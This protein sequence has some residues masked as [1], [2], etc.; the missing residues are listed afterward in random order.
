MDDDS[1][2]TEFTYN[3]PGE[4][5]S[6][7][8]TIDTVSYTTGA[9]YN[10]M[11]QLKSV[12]YPGAGGE[13]VSYAYD[14]GGFLTQVSSPL[15]TYAVFSNNYTVLGQP[16]TLTYGDGAQTTHEYSPLT[17][18]L[19][20]L[21]TTKG[22]LIQDLRYDYDNIGNI[23][24]ITDDLQR[25]GVN[26]S[27]GFTYDHLNRLK[28]A[29]FISQLEGQIVY[30]YGYD[31]IG[32]ITSV[33][34]SGGPNP[35]PNLARRYPRTIHYNVDNLPYEILT[36]QVVLASFVYD[37]AGKRVSKTTG[38]TTTLYIG[39]IYES[40]GGVSTN[41]IFAGSRR[42]ASKTTGGAVFYYHADHLG[43]LNAATSNGT[44]G[45]Q[46]TVAYNPFGEVRLDT[47]NVN[48]DYKFTGKEYDP[49]AGGGA[50][51][52]D[53]LYYY[54]ARYYD[55]VVGRF[56]SP[57]S[58]VPNPG[59]PQS[60]NR[61]AYCLNNPINVID[62]TGHFS[63]GSFFSS[64]AGGII[65]AF[66]FAFTGDPVLS[67]VAA[68]GFSGLM[69]G[70]LQNMF[71]GALMG[72]VS[73]GLGMVV[74]A[75]FG[76]AGTLAMLGIGA[77]SAVATGG[78]ESL[79]YMG[80][81]VVGG[82]IGDYAAGYAARYS[83]NESAEFSKAMRASSGGYDADALVTKIDEYPVNP[84]GPYTSK[85]EAAMAA[86]QAVRAKSASDL[87]YEWGCWIKVAE[88]DLKAFYG[89]YDC[90][91]YTLI[92][93]DYLVD[94]VSPGLKPYGAVADF[95]SHVRL[96]PYKFNIFSPDDKDWNRYFGV[97]GYLLT[98]D[99]GLLRYNP[100]T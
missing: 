47:G 43:S 40:T 26:Y 8:K 27:Q 92:R 63:L 53:G 70:N 93:S 24:T 86:A 20:T 22:S 11:G 38:A 88:P 54:G 74:Q 84:N 71:T 58:I 95:H 98:P 90:Y 80:A 66:T 51:A 13:T 100:P 52:T 35:Y 5:I 18:R 28:T 64:L 34:N 19:H 14:A 87:R 57:D 36:N 39:D 44:N 42:I 23:L 29:G 10:A 97:S 32:N 83:A 2:R 91:D 7:T 69:S 94:R 45:P 46:E 82:A 61:Y 17:N 75:N 76:T 9:T 62:P 50:G 4:V 48:L 79:A 15:T 56:I 60:L 67:G 16:G 73:G 25:P 77:G 68:G 1:G 6:T 12:T 65:G 31:K 96:Y 33:T 72:G 85:D 49:E 78:W 41:H 99:R 37:Y 81:G 55:P 59:N 3:I 21:T 30:T 89:E